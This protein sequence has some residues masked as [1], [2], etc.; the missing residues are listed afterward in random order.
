MAGYDTKTGEIFGC[1][2]KSMLWWHEK[3]HLELH[4]TT[5]WKELEMYNGYLV[6]IILALLCV[7][8]F[9]IARILFLVYLILPIEDEFIAWSYCFKHK[10]EW[11]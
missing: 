9:F 7:E 1:K 6:L 4:N 11:R 8:S 5:L 10:N 3:G 2:D